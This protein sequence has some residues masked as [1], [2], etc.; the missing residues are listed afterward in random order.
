MADRDAWEQSLYR[1]AEILLRDPELARKVTLETLEAAILKPPGD[2]ERVAMTLFVGI[3]R[4]AL[5][6]KGTIIPPAAPR[7]ELPAEAAAVAPEKIAA[8]LH[9]LP[10][11]GRSALALLLLDVMEADHIAKVLGLAEAELA[12]ALHSARL[13]LH[14][15]LAAAPDSI[16]AAP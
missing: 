2:A 13:A 12:T 9:A 7:A 8:A 1:F 15:A 6:N 14:A 10:E 4:R 11:P 5:R 16:T 3:R